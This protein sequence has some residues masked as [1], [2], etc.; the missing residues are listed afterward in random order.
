MSI[1]S[2]TNMFLCFV[3]L[4]FAAITAAAT[5]IAINNMFAKWWQPVQ[6][7]V[8]TWIDHHTS[9]N[10]DF[11]HVVDPTLVPTPVDPHTPWPAPSPKS[12]KK[13]DAKA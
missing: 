8:Y 11:Q 1:E 12:T 6:W 13:V 5:I 7:S 9:K 3:M 4:G 2:A 10:P